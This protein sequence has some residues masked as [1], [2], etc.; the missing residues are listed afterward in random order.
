[1]KFWVIG[2]GPS[3]RDVAS[4]YAVNP[5]ILTLGRNGTRDDFS[6]LLVIVVSSL[7]N[8]LMVARCVASWYL[9]VTYK[10]PTISN[11]K[12]ER[13]HLK[14]TRDFPDFLKREEGS[15][16][17]PT[18]FIDQAEPA[19]SILSLNLSFTKL[20][21]VFILKYISGSLRPHSYLIKGV[22]FFHTCLTSQEWPFE[23]W[24]TT[25]SMKV[26]RC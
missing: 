23:I 26:T 5:P 1:M 13:G 8:D 2:T 3:L 20:G 15:F 16:L 24:D 19:I 11:R 9:G 7:P 10:V 4:L 12:A 14:N 18:K 21:C 17:V 6:S 25:T 22:W